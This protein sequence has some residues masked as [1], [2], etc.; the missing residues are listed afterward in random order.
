VPR[1]I[2][3]LATISKGSCYVPAFLVLDNTAK[4]VA[5]LDAPLSNHLFEARGSPVRFGKGSN[6]YAMLQE[7]KSIDRSALYL[8]DDAGRLAFQE[9][10]EAAC[11]GLIPLATAGGE[12][13]LIGCSNTVFAYDLNP[14]ARKTAHSI[15]SQP[16]TR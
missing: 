12:Q 3:A 5:E 10:L 9:I 7:K 16:L 13:L 4:T 11:G 2:L 14:Q 15:E 8:Y 6:Y 1:H